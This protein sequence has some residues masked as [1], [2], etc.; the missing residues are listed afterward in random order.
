VI[1]S[2]NPTVQVKK[3][4][5]TTTKTTAEEPLPLNISLQPELFDQKEK[6]E[7]TGQIPAY[8]QPSITDPPPPNS[9]EVGAAP[10]RHAKG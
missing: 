1:H 9:R 7:D 8:H 10:S 3:E 4:L 2:P 6:T 5:M